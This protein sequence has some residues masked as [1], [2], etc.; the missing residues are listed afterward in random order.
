MSTDS[1]IAD[2]GKTLVKLLQEHMGDMVAP[3]SIA[4]QSPADLTG[5]TV[6]ITLFLFHLAENPF[7]KN[8]AGD[9]KYGYTR[10]PPLTLDLYYMLSAYS[11]L[12]DLT[13][14]SLEE[15]RLLGRAMRILH[16]CAELGGTML[17]GDLSGGE[18][19]LRI[20]HQPASVQEVAEIW[21]TFPDTNYKPSVCYIV[22]PV[23]IDSASILLPSLVKEREVHYAPLEAERN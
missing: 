13:E 7:L 18:E 22:S 5:R 3:G 21:N 17:Q 6:R 4:L 1:A 8:Q 10:L 14:R 12:P 11:Y 19:K 23:V 15:H 20:T 2:V 16:D 9:P